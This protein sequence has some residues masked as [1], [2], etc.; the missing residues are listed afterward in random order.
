M[1]LEHLHDPLGDLRRLRRWL[2]P[3][4]RLVLS[5]P[6]AASWELGMFRGAWYALQ[7]PHHLWHFSPTTVRAVLAGA[8]WQVDRI[9]QQRNVANLSASLAYRAADAGH[10]RLAALLAGLPVN[11]GPVRLAF[12]PL[13]WVLAA[14][15]QSGRMTI[16]ACPLPDAAGEA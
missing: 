14:A 7:L 4:G 13:A 5:V 3:G 16:W 8:G 15:G 11:R 9:M 2:R 1:V 12:F 6:N 10:R